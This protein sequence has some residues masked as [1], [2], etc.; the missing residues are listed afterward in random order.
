MNIKLFITGSI[1]FCFTSVH[2]QTNP[3][4]Y[5]NVIGEQFNNISHEMMS[6]QSA[7]NHGKSARKIEKRRQEFMAQIKESEKTVRRL[8][9]FDGKTTLRDSIAAYF[10]LIQIILNEEYGKILDLEE[11]SEQSYDAM[12][13]YLLAKERASDKGD[14]AFQAAMTQY[15]A[16]AAENN[17]KLLEN[18]SEL[19]EKLEKT[20]LILQY[21]N[22]AYLLFFK[23]YKNEAYM[24]DAMKRDDMAAVEQLRNAL[25]SSATEDL[26]KVKDLGR[27]EGDGSLA[28][29]AQQALTFYKMEADEKIP[30]FTAFLLAKD[31]MEKVKK[32]F[33]GTAASKRTQQ[34]IDAYNKAI[35]DF[36]SKVNAVNAMNQE[37]NKKRT[38]MLKSWND[39][40][41]NFLDKHTPR[42][43]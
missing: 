2:S 13:A 24:I 9:P 11:I 5:L 32:S 3:V 36:N 39:T 8:R 6:Y 19:Y 27:F 12:E 17:I 23:S 42:Y 16:F 35:N 25:S 33:D 1:L 34:Q 40:Y 15:Q 10:K 43:K 41:E 29:A 20:G 26:V 37:V 18:K 22:K 30:V 7:V 14:A 31:N 28:T 38:V 4:E 21:S